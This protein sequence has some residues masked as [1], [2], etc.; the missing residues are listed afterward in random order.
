MNKALYQL[1]SQP[2]STCGGGTVVYVNG[3]DEEDTLYYDGIEER[4]DAGTPP[5]IQKIRASLAFWL[6]EY[7]GY[8]N[9]G[10]REQV[11]T[12][13]VMKMLVGN[14][15]VK[16]FNGLKPG[17]TR[18]SFAYYLSKDELKFILAAIEF[19]AE[20][21][22]RFLPLYEFDWKTGDWTFRKLEIK[23]HTTKQQLAV[24]ANVF[25]LDEM[26]LSKV[27]VK[28]K[29]NP[30]NNHMKFE[31]YLESAKIIA[32]SLPNISQHTV[33]L[34]KGIDTDMVLFHI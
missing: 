28:T 12:E 4:E 9:M 15:N 21:G 30:E 13:M 27:A 14:P 25:H 3:F 23:Y 19:I 17:W 31:R 26:R 7:I 18:L 10:L 6:K 8:H 32:L 16:G 24:A 29:R 33:D 1:N 20:Y 2:P 11:Y 22:H 5:I 34:P